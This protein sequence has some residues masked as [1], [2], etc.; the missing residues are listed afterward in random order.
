MQTTSM[1]EITTTLKFEGQEASK[2]LTYEQL[3]YAIGKTGVVSSVHPLHHI[4]Q[5]CT[6]E[7]LK[8]VFGEK[9]SGDAKTALFGIPVFKKNWVPMSDI[10]MCNKDG[11]I[12]Q[13]FSVS[14]VKER[15]MAS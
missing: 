3:V 9:I 11:E 4:N 5:N 15:G 8:M 14:G 12:L 7:E 6:D 13:K 10:W 2:V 1:D